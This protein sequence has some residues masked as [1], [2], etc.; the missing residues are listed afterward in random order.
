[1]PYKNPHHKTRRQRQQRRAGEVKRVEIVLSADSAR[2]RDIHD[3]LASLPRGAV[4]EF[5][6]AAILEKMQRDN[7][8]G[9]PEAPSA[10]AQFNTILAELAALRKAV[11]QPGYAPTGTRTDP[12]APPGVVASSGLDL[13]RPRQAP[14]GA[15]V[16]RPAPPVPEELTE[17]QRIELAQQL[18]ASIKAYGTSGRT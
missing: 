1:M 5:I 4:S 3:F 18:V 7:E 11:T 17:A 6:K 13:S 16:P 2:D 10:A 9:T 15:R 14:T 12:A 8:H